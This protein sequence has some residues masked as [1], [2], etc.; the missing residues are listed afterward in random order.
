MRLMQRFPILHIPR[1]L[2]NARFHASAKSVAQKTQSAFEAISVFEGFFSQNLPDEIL[3]LRN[4]VLSRA[5]LWKAYTYYTLG[6]MA[7]ARRWAIIALKLNPSF[8]SALRVLRL[9]MR[10]VATSRLSRNQARS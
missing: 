8:T 1:F 9:L 7:E 3:G 5:Y 10:T 2:A 4:P 6:Q